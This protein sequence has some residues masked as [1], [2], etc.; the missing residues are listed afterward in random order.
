MSTRYVWERYHVNHNA[1]A[2][3]GTSVAKAISTASFTIS[4]SPPRAEMYIEGDYANRPFYRGS[5][6]SFTQGGVTKSYPVSSYG[7]YLYNSN[8]GDSILCVVPDG[9]DKSNLVWLVGG[10]VR[11]SIKESSGAK[12]FD[13]YTPTVTK[14]EY[15]DIVG[16]NRSDAHKNGY[17]GSTYW[18]VYKGSEVIDPT[19]IYLTS[20]KIVPG[21]TATAIVVAPKIQYKGVYYYVS[22][23]VNGGEYQS[24]PG[25]EEKTFTFI[26]PSNAESLR[27][28]VFAGSD[29]VVKSKYVYSITYYA[30][31]A[32]FAPSSVSVPDVIYPEESFAVTWGASTDPDGNL[33]GYEV[34]RS[35]D[36]GSWADVT[37]TSST[38]ITTSVERGKENVQ[39][40][41]RAYD[42]KGEYSSWTYSNTATIRNLRAYVG[43]NGKAR[44]ADKLYIGV[45]GKAMQVV[46]GYVG[47]NGKARKFL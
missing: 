35:Y 17:D 16:S 46:K 23:S 31:E 33:S 11:L 43:I 6:T 34:Q 2:T 3:P 19:D 7:E 28:R 14:G 4:G 41:V 32:P 44:K 29:G 39:Y 37:T 1:F 40:R 12:S 13:T 47:V 24:L 9:Y 10:Y 18:Y 25:Q 36:S 45:N 30:N 21:Q 22:Y 5:G 20:T 15:V 27:L 8:P 42:S 38:S 26:V